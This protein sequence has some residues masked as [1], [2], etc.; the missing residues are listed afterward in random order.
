MIREVLKSYDSCRGAVEIVD[1]IRTKLMIAQKNGEGLG[2]AVRV[3]I[4]LLLRMS[5]SPAVTLAGQ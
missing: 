4:R 2:F 5:S 3:G 1:G